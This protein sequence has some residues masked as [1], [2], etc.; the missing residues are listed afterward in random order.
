MVGIGNDRD[1][2]ERGEGEV[3]SEPDCLLR[4]FLEPRMGTDDHG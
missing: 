4:S 1:G 2:V 3:P